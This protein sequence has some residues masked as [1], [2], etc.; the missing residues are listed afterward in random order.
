[1]NINEVNAHLE[2]IAERYERESFL[3]RVKKI[4]KGL[5]QPRNSR[6]HKEALIEGQRLAAPLSAI[7]LPLIAVVLLIVL[8]GGSKVRKEERVYPARPVDDTFVKTLKTLPKPDAAEVKTPTTDFETYAGGVQTPDTSMPQAVKDNSSPEIL[9]GFRTGPDLV[10]ITPGP[11]GIGTG[12]GEGVEKRKGTPT[13]VSVMRALRWLK[14]NQNADGSW[15]KNKSAMTGMAVLAF[16]AHAETP[17]GSEEFGDTVQRA[18]QFLMDGQ[19]QTTGLFSHQDG[20]QYSHPIATYA[21]CEAAAMT[22]NPNVKRS[23]ELALRLIINGQNPSGGWNYKMESSSG[24]NDTSYMGWCAQALKAAKMARLKVD[25]LDKAL[26]L[27]VAGFKQNSNPGGGFGYVGPSSSHGM[28]A[29]G[30]LCMKILGA[31]NDPVVKNS[32]KLMDAWT[33]GQFDAVNKVG[34]CPQ[35]YFYYATQ[36]KFHSQGK[37]WERWDREMQSVY[38]PAQIIEKN[39]IKDTDGK[40]QDIGWWQN[41]DKHTDRP[42]MDTCLT[43]L[44]L[45]VY[46]RYL[47]TMTASA[48]KVE[49]EVLARSVDDKGD[50]K[51]NIGDL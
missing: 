23:A 5:K 47:P 37:S 34:G 2:E 11:P 17:A 13:D 49:D 19:N 22:G 36:S 9:K 42:V 24:R 28:T 41:G 38:L 14:K 21:M 45:M 16:L 31:G 6:E 4:F 25:G 35:Y 10:G 12:R 29:V 7:L 1:M 27:A 30:T 33:I 48:V 39:A 44:Q 3:H 18:L 8:A 20:H 43:A 15:N 50:I 26:K 32:D 51:V 46:H 40:D